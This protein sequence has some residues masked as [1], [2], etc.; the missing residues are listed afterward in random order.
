MLFTWLGIGAP[1]ALGFPPIALIGLGLFGT[2]MIATGLHRSRA[3]KLLRSPPFGVTW[4]DPPTAIE[5]VIL[6]LARA[7]DD[8]AAQSLAE[9]LLAISDLSISI[10]DDRMS[11][12]G[13]TW[14]WDDQLLLAYVLDTWG[15]R[16]HAEHGLVGITVTPG[17]TE[18]EL[19]FLRRKKSR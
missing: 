19:G 8:E 5:E 2:G 9:A 6:R 18:R 13:W 11:L 15:R 1:A 7:P 3:K 17:K 16:V 10:V 14:N 12:T 4:I